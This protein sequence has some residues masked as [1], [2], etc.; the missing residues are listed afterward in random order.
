V[1]ELRTLVEQPLKQ[2][3][4]ASESLMTAAAHRTVMAMMIALEW[5]RHVQRRLTESVTLQTDLY[6][7]H[8]EYCTITTS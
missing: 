4:T 8:V 5:M 6:E 7:H 1:V 2:S 3:D